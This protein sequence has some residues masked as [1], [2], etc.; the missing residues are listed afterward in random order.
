MI[1]SKITCRENSAG[2]FYWKIRN[3]IQFYKMTGFDI[4]VLYNI[5]KEDCRRNGKQQDGI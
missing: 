3:E 1:D 5:V 2:Y 4:G